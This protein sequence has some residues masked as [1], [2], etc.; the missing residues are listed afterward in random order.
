MA[1]AAGAVLLAL[2]L[3]YLLSGHRAAEVVSVPVTV[4]E[5]SQPATPMTVVVSPAKLPSPPVVAVVPP[6]AVSFSNSVMLLLTNTGEMPKLPREAI[7]RWL[8]SGRTNAEDLLAARQAG[9]DVEFLRLALTNFPNDPRVLV[10]A[11]ALEETP[12]ERRARLDRL[13]AAAPDNALADYLSARDHLKSGQTAEALA[14]LTAAS[15]KKGFQDYSLDALQNAEELYLQA[16]KS[17]AE[18][19][20]LAANSCLLPHLVQFKGLAQDLAGLEAQYLAAGDPVS[21]ERIAQLGLQLGQHLI[22]GEGS[23]TLIGQLVG[24]AVERI[25]LKPLDAAKNYDFLQ[26]TVPD[27]I[28]QLDARRLAVRDSTKSLD[29]WM[30]NAN[31]ADLISYFDRFKLSGEA[32]ALAW[33]R[34]RQGA[35]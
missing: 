19:K 7:D 25:S 17:P 26:G 28:A 35:Q 1:V 14:D 22:D 10:A 21:A 18:A 32:G 13:K 16:G 30:R 11:S 8:A 33:M 29:S 34:Q 6:S 31:E 27:R 20:L 24:I 12:A 9:G 3:V 5:A 2:G 4:E 15:G 23:R